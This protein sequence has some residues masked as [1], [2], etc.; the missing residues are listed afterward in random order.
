MTNHP[1]TSITIN[2]DFS[3]KI[4][5]HRNNEGLSLITAI[6]NYI[7]GN[8]LYWEDDN[9]TM[10]LEEVS[11]HEPQVN[12][13]QDQA[14]LMN[15]QCA[16]AVEAF[17]GTRYSIILFTS[18]TYQN[19]DEDYVDIL[20]RKGYNWPEAETIRS[21]MSQHYQPKGYQTIR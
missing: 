6:G 9:R 20:K 15:G 19:L 13:L 12:N 4:H 5:R 14:F 1:F 16:H 8:L 18:S 7:G 17:E 11:T 2:S 3:A 10:T 21:T